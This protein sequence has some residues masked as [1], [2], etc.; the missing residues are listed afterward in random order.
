[1]THAQMR[2]FA[3]FLTLPVLALPGFAQAPSASSTFTTA[4]LNVTP[5]PASPSQLSLPAGT[6]VV[7]FDI[8]PTGADAVILTH[9]KAGNH[10]VSWH[11]GDTSA[12]PLLD[13]PATFSASAIAVHPTGQSFFI[14]GKTGAQ[15]QILVASQANGSWTQHM[16][17]QTAADVRRLLVAPRPFETG[18]NDTTDQTIESYRLFFAE[19]LPT[20]CT[21]RVRLPKT[22][23]ANTRCSGHSRLM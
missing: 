15:S 16:I 9:D 13:L 10:V 14:E 5:S 20:A 19:R 4:E 12:V 8:L 6:T 11:A 2:A 22:A 17:Y 7:D 1:M 23:S 18:Y 21:P 3:L